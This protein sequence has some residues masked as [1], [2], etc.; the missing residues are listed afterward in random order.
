MTL[1]K[2]NRKKKKMKNGSRSPSPA[3]GTFILLSALLSHFKRFRRVEARIY[4]R[5]SG[6][7]TTL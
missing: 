5:L 7:A 4:H 1:K 6:K 2:L 3:V